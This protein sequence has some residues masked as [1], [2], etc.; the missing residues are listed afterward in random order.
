MAG[1]IGLKIDRDK[2][3][4]IIS[5][6]Q[7]GLMDIILDVTGMEDSNPKYTPAEKDPL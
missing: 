1:F 7:T 5:L 2:E 6:T 4:G 3:K